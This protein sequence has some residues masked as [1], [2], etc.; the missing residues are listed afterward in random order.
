MTRQAQ[1]KID[2]VL[3]S[4]SRAMA[5]IL[6]PFSKLEE[7]KKK[8]TVASSLTCRPDG[9]RDSVWSSEASE[10]HQLYLSFFFLP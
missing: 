4:G 8:E 9:G 3:Q 5:D 10:Q 1:S 7:K 6:R 2:K